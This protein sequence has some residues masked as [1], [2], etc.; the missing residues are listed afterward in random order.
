MQ[1][2]LT[3]LCKYVSRGSSFAEIYRGDCDSEFCQTKVDTLSAL[4]WNL[5]QK[6]KI[7]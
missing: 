3:R 1:F 4:R 2:T 5:L 6:I 7:K